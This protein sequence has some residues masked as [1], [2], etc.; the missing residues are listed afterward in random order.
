MAEDYDMS[1]AHQGPLGPPSPT[2]TRITIRF[3]NDILAWFKAQVH[4]QGGGNYQTLMN[5]ALR[6]YMKRREVDME[7]LLRRIVREELAELL[8]HLSVT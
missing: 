8:K 4:E 3:D 7:V 6:D 1:D 5:Q 2:K